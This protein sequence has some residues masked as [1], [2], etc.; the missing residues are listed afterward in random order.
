MALYRQYRPQRFADVV[1]HTAAKQT[2]Q[3]GLKEGKPAGSYLFVGPRGIGKTTLARLIAI[4]LN[5]SNFDAQTGEPCLTCDSCLAVVAGNH[6]DVLEIDAASN[7]GIDE[8]RALKET[9]A[10]QPSQGKRRVF[11]IDEVHMLTKEA[12]NAL[13]K[14]LE[15]PPAHVVF[16]LATT[17][18]SKVPATIISRCQRF[19]LRPADVTETVAG[20]ERILAGEQRVAEPAAVELLALQA[21]G[22]HRDA[23]SLLEQALIYQQTGALT[24]AG[25]TAALGLPDRQAVISVLQALSDGDVSLMLQRLRALE[26]SGAQAPE[27]GRLLLLFWQAMLHLHYQSTLNATILNV[28]A[29]EAEQLQALAKPWSAPVL[30]QGLREILDLGNQIKQS[31][32]PFLPLELLLLKLHQPNETPARPQLT[33]RPTVAAVPRPPDIAQTAVVPQVASVEEPVRASNLANDV[34]TTPPVAAPAGDLASKWPALLELLRAKNTSVA[35]LMREAN[36]GTDRDGKLQLIVRFSFHQKK[37]AQAENRQIIEEA[38]ASLL[39]RP[40]LVT[41][42]LADQ[43]TVVAPADTNTAE[44]DIDQLVNDVLGGQPLG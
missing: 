6:L 13:L 8:I 30:L 11:I 34:P 12:W 22:G 28:T 39:G 9:V 20:L 14:T 44:E 31:P 16:I 18:V 5:C 1:G 25:I 4:S 35:A 15:E 7:R 38:L 41:V 27:V 43:A 40:T 23:A 33:P 24:A 36:P 26:T 17:E 3:Q 10:L 21:S 2:I 29:A 19:D 37:L 32:L 42:V